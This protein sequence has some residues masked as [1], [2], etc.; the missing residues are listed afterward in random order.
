MLQICVLA[1]KSTAIRKLLL[2]NTLAIKSTTIRKLLLVNML[3]IKSTTTRTSL[4]GSNQMTVPGIVFH[5]EWH[6]NT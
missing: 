4:T 5:S 1:I 6:A 3:A 2:V